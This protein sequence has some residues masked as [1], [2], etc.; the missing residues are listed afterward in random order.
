MLEYK[1]FNI[2]EMYKF[3][4]CNKNMKNCVFKILIL[5]KI[6]KIKRNIFL[7]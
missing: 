1:L 3:F 5:Q 7:Q 2:K 4:V 6:A